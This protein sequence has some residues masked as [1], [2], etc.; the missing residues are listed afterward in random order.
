MKP[1]LP[2]VT[3]FP[4]FPLFEHITGVPDK[5]ET[6][7]TRVANTIEDIKEKIKN[8]DPEGRY[9]IQLESYTR[10]PLAERRQARVV[11]NNLR[12]KEPDLSSAKDITA[13]MVINKAMK[14]FEP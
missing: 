10:L 7:S 6:L 12:E 11:F 2:E 14:S 8:V 13:L 3:I 5:I 9:Q 1:F 4:K